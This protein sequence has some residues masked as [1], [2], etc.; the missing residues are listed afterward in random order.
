MR[1]TPISVSLASAYAA[2]GITQTATSRQP[3]AAAIT[4]MNTL[5]PAEAAFS[6][7]ART[8]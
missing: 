3:G 5:V 1:T 2:G 7:R 4:F 8:A 6:S